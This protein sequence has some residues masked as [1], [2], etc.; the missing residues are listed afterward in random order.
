MSTHDVCCPDVPDVSVD[1]LLR[2]ISHGEQDT[3]LEAVFVASVA[4][5]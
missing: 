3:A 1:C 5:C 4:G 2:R